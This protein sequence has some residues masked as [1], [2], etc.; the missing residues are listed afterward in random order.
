MKLAFFRHGGGQSPFS[1]TDEAHIEARMEVMARGLPFKPSIIY[2]SPYDKA[3]ETARVIAKVKKASYTTI[4]ELSPAIASFE[5]LTRYVK[6][7]AV[8]VGHSPSIEAVVVSLIGG[9][10]IKLDP[11]GFAVVEAT[12]YAHGAGVLVF[13][14]NPDYLLFLV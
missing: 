2:S 1:G 6:D 12:K 4:T 11:G 7:G 3:V 13:L 8:F 10:N 9:G 5:A 14:A